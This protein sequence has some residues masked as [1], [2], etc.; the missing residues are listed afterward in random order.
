MK[1]LKIFIFAFFASF[2]CFA[3]S[4]QQTK[5]IKVEMYFEPFDTQGWQSYLNFD[6]VRKKVKSV[7]LSVYPLINKNQEGKYFSSR[8][9]IET[10][11]VA[12]IEAI[13]SKNPDKLNDYLIARSLN[14]YPDGWKESL[15]YAGIN[16]VE[17]D[18]Y[19]QKNKEALLAKAYKRAADKKINGMSVFINSNPYSGSVRITDVMESVN[20]YLSGDKKINLYKN[21]MASIKG[22]KFKIVYDDVTK[23]WVDQN[24]TDTFKRLFSS[25]DVEKIELSKLSEKEKEKLKMLPAYMIEKTSEVKEMLSGA[26]EQNAFDNLENY[27]VYYNQ[28]S[29]VLM[30]N[31][32]SEKKKLE[33]F[34][35][36]QCPFG[37]MAEN[38]VIN[39]VENSKI[40][41]DVKLEIH[42]IGDVFKDPDGNMKFH[43]LHGDEEW[44]E[45]ARQIL[46]KKIY[47]EKYFAYLKERN[48]NYSSP[49]WKEAAKKAGVNPEVVEK[50]FDEAKELLAEDFKYVNSLNINVSP[51]FIVDGNI[52][53][54]GLSQLKS[55]EDYKDIEL[56]Q[57]GNQGGC[58]K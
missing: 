48:K 54:V 3:Q 15:I 8:G 16:P 11:E 18:D 14:M 56:S 20:N 40:S 53:V 46:I 25:L 58:G 55:F 6:L 38:S 21:E 45:N 13:I 39:A 51:T 2:Y 35:M 10:T 57:T 29:K 41:K 5:E 33:M 31:K 17:F 7:R 9:E 23:D 28:N 4:P 34:V 42:Y 1:K 43:S 19:V 32:K 50:R 12:R 27:Y 36:S 47:P 24:I 37:V 52:L 22:P 30:L 26:I 49:E 44:K